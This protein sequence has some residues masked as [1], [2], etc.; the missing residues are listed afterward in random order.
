L[1]I[2]KREKDEQAIKN[3]SFRFRPRGGGGKE[4]KESA[5]GG[6][7]ILASIT[8]AWDEET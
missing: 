6:K 7:R 2:R 5:N 8:T 4:K 3:V 1:R